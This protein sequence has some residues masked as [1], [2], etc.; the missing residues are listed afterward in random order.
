LTSLERGLD[1]N[2]QVTAAVIFRGGKVLIA[3]R[4]AGGR[5]HGCW[6][7]PGGKVEP[8][9]SHEECLAREMSEEMALNVSVGKPVADVTHRYPD[10][11][12]RLLAFECEILEG[13][14][15]D[16]GCAEHAWVSPDEM[17]GYDLLPPDREIAR[18]IADSR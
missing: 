18:V 7:F 14:P 9:E 4:P 16:L 12:I 1:E 17:G 10:L 11:G 5:H 8:G 2:V 6:E 3:R 15:E 13:E